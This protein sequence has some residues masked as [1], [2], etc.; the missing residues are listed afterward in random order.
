MA[1][2]GGLRWFSK[3]N[4]TVCSGFFYTVAGTPC[5]DAF[6]VLHING[7]IPFQIRALMKSRGWTQAQLAEK[8]HMLQPRI[9]GLICLLKSL[10]G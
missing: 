3:G 9:S 4:N 1:K 6:V 7:G 10:D 8:T 2:V 5:R